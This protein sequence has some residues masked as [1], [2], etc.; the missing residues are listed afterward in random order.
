MR[1]TA[2]WSGW[3]TAGATV[4]VAGQA[5]A[6]ES[7]VRALTW[8]AGLAQADA[9]PGK[10]F[11]LAQ[12]AKDLWTN[13]ELGGRTMWFILALSIMGLAFSLERIV[14]LRRKAI[15][16]KGLGEK[17]NALWQEKKYDEIKALCARHP[18]AM[19][20]IITF[21]VKHRTA[22]VTDLVAL[23]GDLGSREMEP[24]FRR[25]YPLAVVATLAPLLGLYGTVAGMIGAF[26]DFRL[27]GET[28]D[29][30]IFAGNI[31]LA[32]ITTAA[33]LIV[34]MPSLAAYHFFRSLANRYRD[35]LEAEVGE[36][37]TEWKLEKAGD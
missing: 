31:S 5:L 36:L 29:P 19:G 17:V 18:S 27:L 15:V 35:D 13:F 28:G 2:I 1:T 20:R 4:L 22:P 32:M 30:S 26:Q 3:A 16:P 33:G 9:A 12:A 8:T 25:V 10:G 21:I 7:T 34:A 6:E 23:V 11:D 14:R 37:L 24:H